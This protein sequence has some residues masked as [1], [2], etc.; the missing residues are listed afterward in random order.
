[1][2][3]KCK[4]GKP[5][6]TKDDMRRYI[7]AG[8]VGDCQCQACSRVCWLSECHRAT[9]PKRKARKP[10]DSELV[11]VNYDGGIVLLRDWFDKEQAK[12]LHAW[13]SR[14]LAWAEQQQQKGE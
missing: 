1:M 4:H 6:A 2:T 3:T 12:Q 11:W 8:C 7:L 5:V 9:K 14:Y 13:L 10:K